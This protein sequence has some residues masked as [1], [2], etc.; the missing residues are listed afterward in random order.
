VGA[1]DD[2]VRWPLLLDAIVSMG[3]GLSLDELLER[4]VEIAAA[5]VGARYAALGVLAEGV[6]RRLR[7]FVT[8]GLDPDEI[9][10][11]G[12]LPTGQGVLG[13]L[14]DHPEPVRLHDIT[15]HER[16][17][18]FPAHHPPMHTFLGVPVRTG[19]K[20]FGNL[21]LA[22]KHASGDFTEQDEEILVALA[23]AAGVAIENA[24]LHEDAVRR[25]RWLAARAEITGALMG[26]HFDRAAAL[27]LVADRAREIAGADLA[28]IVSGPAPDELR[29]E[30]VSGIEID[31]GSLGRAPLR[32]SIAGRAVRSGSPL[33]IE[34]LSREGDGGASAAVMDLSHIGP[35]VMVPLRAAESGGSTDIPAAATAAGAGAADAVGVLAL[36]WRH[37]NAERATRVD[38]TVADAFAEQVALAIRLAQ[39]R[40]DQERLAVYDDRDRIG[41]D[42]HDIVIQ[43]LFGIGLRLQ[44]GL[45]WTDD[46]RLRE[47]LDEAVDE[48]DDTIRDIRRTIFELGRTERASGDLQSQVTE[49]VDRAASSLKFRPTLTFHGPLRLT[50][51]PA[52]AQDVLAVLGEALSNTV[53]HAHA[54]S[55]SVSLSAGAALTLRVE[56]DGDGIP[57]GAVES[58]MANMRRRAEANGGVCT[59]SPRTP[60]GTVVEWTVPLS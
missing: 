18:G 31:H 47:R 29:V 22:E 25:E 59:V 33:A 51:G 13:L 21:Y 57:V 55:V 2:E 37:E 5:L 11:I 10:R 8:T 19:E 28:W 36:A 4:I 3:A 38:L 60:R 9:A 14:I 58:G 17:T 45:K 7:L 1:A 40:E 24:R 46:P 35:A 44:G 43:R 20:V 15:A 34:D 27:Q 52:V 49:L 42:L 39:G 48:I 12:P 32:Q 41:R 6:D 30:A 56:D 26:G 54:R 23:A 53:R 50:V 16:S